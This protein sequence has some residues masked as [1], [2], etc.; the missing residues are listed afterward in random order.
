MKNLLRATAFK[1]REI[2]QPGSEERKEF[3]AEPET[4][5][6]VTKI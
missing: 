1:G 2:Y 6:R 5:D 4:Q 3:E